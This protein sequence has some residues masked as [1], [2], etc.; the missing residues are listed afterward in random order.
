VPGTLPK[1]DPPGDAANPPNPPPPIR[2][3]A[4]RLSAFSACCFTFVFSL[5]RVSIL[6]LRSS[7]SFLTDLQPRNKNE[8]RY[9]TALRCGLN[10][11]GASA[12]SSV[13]GRDESAA[14]CDNRFKRT[15][16]ILPGVQAVPCTWRVP[17]RYL[18]SSRSSTMV[19]LATSLFILPFR[20]RLLCDSDSGVGVVKP[21]R[22]QN[23]CSRVGLVI[24][25]ACPQ[26]AWGL[27]RCQHGHRRPRRQMMG[28]RL[29]FLLGYGQASDQ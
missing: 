8:P 24:V 17:N 23:S 7:F 29:P 5:S 25:T 3:S 9:G 11:S 20:S 22:L 1:P 18:S 6:P 21:W 10:L 4:A 13:K 12:S 2:R 14:H 19:S 27:G 26:E 28:L 15:T 16:R